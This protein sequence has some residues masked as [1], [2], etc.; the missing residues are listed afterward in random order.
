VT[1]DVDDHSEGV[2]PTDLHAGGSDVGEQ[3]GTPDDHRGRADSA[4]ASNAGHDGKVVM[5]SSSAA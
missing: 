5:M 3:I 4:S 2:S 1:V